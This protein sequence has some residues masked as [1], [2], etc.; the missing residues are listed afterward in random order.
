MAQLS[1]RAVSD[2]VLAGLRQAAADQHTS[3]NGIA[4]V[5]LEDYIQRR[6]RQ[7]TLKS[8]LPAFDA[9]QRQIL[10]RRGKPLDADS[11]E[12]LAEDRAR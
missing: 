4:R 5:A 8:L 3:L 7:R 10:A 6:R 1:V 12:L 11:A 2:E 9:L